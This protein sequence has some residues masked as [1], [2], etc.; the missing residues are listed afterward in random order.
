[1]TRGAAYVGLMSG[2]SLDG[3]SACVVRFAE[4]TFELLAFQTSEYNAE[5]RAHLARAMQ[6]GTSKEYCRLAFDLGGW[7]ADAAAAVL[8][9]S[10]VPRDEVRAIGTH[11]QSVC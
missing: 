7:L 9:E 2:T 11:G 1:M 6:S 5:Q 4:P 10:G 8:V 3:I